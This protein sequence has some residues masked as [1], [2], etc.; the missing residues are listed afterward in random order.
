MGLKQVEF[1]KSVVLFLLIALSI[2]LTFSI[3]TYTPNLKT[4]E[5]KPTVD[6]SIANQATIE[7]IV[8][9]YKESFFG[10]TMT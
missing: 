4:V 10:S 3:W 1:I 7:D 5:Q 2:I 9:P 6:I 8:K